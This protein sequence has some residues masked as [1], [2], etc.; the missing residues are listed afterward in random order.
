MAG[1]DKD[2]REAQ[3]PPVFGQ[4]LALFFSGLFSFYQFA[5]FEVKKE[6]MKLI[7]NKVLKFKQELVLSLPGFLVCMLPA[8]DEQNSELFKT[9][10]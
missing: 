10:E 4:D 3:N 7:Q 9:I 1:V 6:F 8:L 2:G 5:A